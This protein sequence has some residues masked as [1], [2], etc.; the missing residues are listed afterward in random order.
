MHLLDV[1]IPSMMMESSLAA[2]VGLL[3]LKEFKGS[4]L[5]VLG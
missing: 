3:L 1:L 4:S 5:E 2:G